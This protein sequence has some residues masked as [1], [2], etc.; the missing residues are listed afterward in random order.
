MYIHYILCISITG[1]EIYDK[2]RFFTGDHPATDFEK[3]HNRE[4]H[5]HVEDVDMIDDSS[6]ALRLP[7]RSLLQLQTIATAG[8]FGKNVVTYMCMHDV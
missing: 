6:H 7:T 1:I 2:L 4:E 8:K 3:V 5:I